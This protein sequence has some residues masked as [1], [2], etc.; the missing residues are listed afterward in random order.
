MP[1]P[2]AA[3]VFL[4]V[5][6]VFVPLKTTHGCAPCG[7]FLELKCH[8]P[9][10]HLYS[11]WWLMIWCPSGSHTVALLNVTSYGG[12]SIDPSAGLTSSI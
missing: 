9:L 8:C 12:S 6:D 10:L 5:L 1:L 2:P 4:L 11:N 3:L 7:L